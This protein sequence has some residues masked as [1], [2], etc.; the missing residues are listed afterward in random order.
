[1]SVAIPAAASPEAIRVAMRAMSIFFLVAF[2]EELCVS[3]LY[4]VTTEASPFVR[5]V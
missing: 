1:M 4:V 5:M 2:R 3:R